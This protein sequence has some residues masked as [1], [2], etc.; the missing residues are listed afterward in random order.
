MCL[1][2]FRRCLARD[3]T[4][5]QKALFEGDATDT[6]SDMMR[7]RWSKCASSG[8]GHGSK[9]CP[10]IV[11]RHDIVPLREWERIQLYDA[12]SHKMMVDHGCPKCWATI[13]AEGW[14]DI[15]NTKDRENLTAVMWAEALQ[16]DS[17]EDVSDM[18]ASQ[19]EFDER[20]DPE[21]F[22]LDEYQMNDEDTITDSYKGMEAERSKKR[23]RSLS[24]E[25]TNDENSIPLAPWILRSSRRKPRF[26]TFIPETSSESEA[27]R[28]DDDLR[29]QQR[30]EVELQM[31]EQASKDQYEVERKAREK[32]AQQF[33]SGIGGDPDL[34]RALQA[35]LRENY[36]E[37][38][39]SYEPTIPYTETSRKPKIN[40]HDRSREN[41]EV[42]FT[43]VLT[44][45]QPATDDGRPVTLPASQSSNRHGTSPC[46][47]ETMSEQLATL[48]EEKGAWQK[49]KA[50]LVSQNA[51]LLQ[52]NANLVQRQAAQMRRIQELEELCFGVPDK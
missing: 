9:L 12:V 2:E 50:A 17:D 15:L 45:H 1:Y 33:D 31:G 8:L 42:D 41:V 32:A 39:G 22:D 24:R 10:Y 30:K 43:E 51:K 37:R 48:L 19:E 20:E 36:P 14:A 7:C 47:N 5:L 49:E 35:S 38:R 16:D 21:Q 6:A 40:S 13:S 4:A 44:E 34:A 3:E 27:E 26:G 52:E 46:P 18:D 28:D 11:V 29:A 25:S 23:K